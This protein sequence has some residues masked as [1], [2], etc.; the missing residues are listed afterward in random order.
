MSK[1]YPLII[2][3]GNGTRLWP[4]SRTQSPKQFQKVGGPESNTFF[5]AA[6]LRHK[7]DGF[8]DPVIITSVRHR[9]TIHEQLDEIGVNAQVILE[10]MGRNTGPAVLAAAMMLQEQ[11]HEAVVLVVPADHVIRGD[12]NTTIRAMLPAAEDGYIITYGIK[13]RFAE[14]GFGYIVDDGP[15][16]AHQ[17]PAWLERL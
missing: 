3:G 2:C 13:P 12:L 4:I 16:V 7:E 14:T 6:V 1:I 17:G 15:I 11:D 5:Q 10:P 9:K 8:A